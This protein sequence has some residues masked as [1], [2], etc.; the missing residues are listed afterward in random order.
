MEVDE[1]IFRLGQEPVA[2]SV[3]W[4][5]ATPEVMTKFGI[6]N[7]SAPADYGTVSYLSKNV[8]AKFMLKGKSMSFEQHDG[9]VRPMQDNTVAY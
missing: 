1:A 6:K 8:F 4:W 9:V 3:E 5:T 2:Y 7:V